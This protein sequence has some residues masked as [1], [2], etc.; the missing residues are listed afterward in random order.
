M[1]DFAR[2]IDAGS[3]LPNMASTGIVKLTRDSDETEHA[4]GIQIVRL[5][6][7]KF[8]QHLLGECKL[9]HA[10]IGHPRHARRRDISQLRV[11]R[12]HVNVP[13]ATDEAI[14]ATAYRRQVGDV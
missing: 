10:R 2:P 8:W 4:N 1:A 3:L 12:L 5:L 14:H 6:L 13:H 7:L 9:L 11:K